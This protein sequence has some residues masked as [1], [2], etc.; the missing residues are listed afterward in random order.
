[1][2]RERF[3]LSLNRTG[4]LFLYH[5]MKLLHPVLIYVSGLGSNPLSIVGAPRAYRRLDGVNRC[6]TEKLMMFL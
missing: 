6:I 1:M 5:Y 3:Y 2:G 4:K